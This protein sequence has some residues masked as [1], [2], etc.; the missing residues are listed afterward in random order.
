MF[1]LHGACNLS[2]ISRLSS[3]S[4]RHLQSRHLFSPTFHLV[5]VTQKQIFQQK[6]VTRDSLGFKE[7]I[8]SVYAAGAG[9]VAAKDVTKYLLLCEGVEDLN[10]GLYLLCKNISTDL[11]AHGYSEGTFDLIWLYLRVCFIQNQPLQAARAW[12]HPIIRSTNYTLDRARL[13]RLYFDLLFI[14]NMHKKVLD[15]F[16]KDFER[17]VTKFDCVKL[18]CLSCYKLGTVSAL[19]EGLK[20]L[21]HPS[22]VIDTPANRSYQ[23]LALLAYNLKEFHTA[24]ELLVK[25][26]APKGTD[27]SV[28]LFNKSLMLLVLADR[29]WLKEAVVLLET[30]DRAK[31]NRKKSFNYFAVARVLEIAVR[32]GEREIVQIIKD[33]NLLPYHH[34]ILPEE[35]LEQ[36]LLKEIK[37]SIRHSKTPDTPFVF[38]I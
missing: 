1:C 18:T 16:N 25:Y 33:M 28:P 37:P 36:M 35:G 29:G 11:Q 15:T 34:E 32:Q 31:Y 19:E 10:Y 21:S 23:A 30:R 38:S 3:L 6:A 12:N 5:D 2:L 9:R 17:L 4:L 24:Y 13:A 20:I 22:C 7:E 27:R 14:N 8:R 26:G